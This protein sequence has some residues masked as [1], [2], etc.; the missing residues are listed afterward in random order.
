M[1]ASKTTKTN[2]PSQAL[3]PPIS[4]YPLYPYPPYPFP[5]YNYNTS[6]RFYP[7]QSHNTSPR[8]YPSQSHNTSPRFYPSQ[9]NNNTP[10]PD[11]QKFLEDLDEEFGVGKFT[12]YLESFIDES[13]D[14]LDILELK[15]KDFDKLGITNIG[16]KTKLVRKA[17][18]YCK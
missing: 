5:F 13:I 9:S 16:I 7:S 15:E 3:A 14:V 10:V 11:I 18:L 1:F 2:K 8:I 17:K 4:Q 12:I 6:P